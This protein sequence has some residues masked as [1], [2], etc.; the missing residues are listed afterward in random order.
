[1]DYPVPTPSVAPT[2]AASASQPVADLLG[3]I[4][5]GM[6][7]CTGKTA[8]LK[9]LGG[10]GSHIKPRKKTIRDLIMSGG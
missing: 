10:K 5:G 8:V 7:V 2:N 6:S 1:M 4:F 9:K 3:D